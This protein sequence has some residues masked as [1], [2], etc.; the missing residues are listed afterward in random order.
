MNSKSA[1]RDFLSSYY[2]DALNTLF[3]LYV[4]SQLE[5]LEADRIGQEGTVETAGISAI[6]VRGR[7]LQAAGF[8]LAH[9]EPFDAEAAS[10]AAV[11]TRRYLV[12]LAE[13]AGMPLLDYLI[14][15][16]GQARAI[17]G[18]CKETQR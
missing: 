4:G 12:E 14:I 5:L 17:R 6:L 2:P 13:E 16:A 18:S 7:A 3:V 11:R 9:C 15:S 8:I 10:T 1:V